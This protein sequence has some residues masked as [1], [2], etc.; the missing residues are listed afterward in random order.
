MVLRR[1]LIVLLAVACGVSVANLYYNQP[2]LVD[3]ARSFGA[4]SR[5]AGLIATLSQAGYA[6]GMLAFVPLSDLL[7]RRRLIVVLQVA[8]AAALAVVALAPTYAVVAAGS[9][10]IGLTTVIPQII[11]PTAGALAEPHQRGRVI[12]S[13]YTGLLLGILLARTLS[14][15][16]G[17][18]WGWRMMFAVAAGGAVAVAAVLRARMPKS[19]P[20][21]THSYPELMRSLVAMVR[22]CPELREAA[23]IGG[24]LFGSFSAFWTTL[25]FHLAAPPFHY[26]ARAAGLF[27]V[28]GTVGAIAAPVAG[29]VADRRGPKFVIGIGIAVTLAAWLIFLATGSTIAGLVLGVIVLDAGVQGAHV[30]NQTRIFALAQGAQGRAN[31]VYM[32]SYFTGG[33]VASFLAAAAWERWNWAGVCAVGAGLALVAAAAHVR[34]LVASREPEPAE[35]AG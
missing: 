30:C 22:T 4:S 29:R 28:I 6:V 21:A 19:S 3:M 31:T 35:A 24:A 10:L 5:Q 16:V 1:N 17:Q 12:G 34:G 20:P 8:V 11:I 32:I 18:Q 27:G 7:E 9:F 25:A 26:G 23:V 14:G 33:A 2:L 13:L 15:F